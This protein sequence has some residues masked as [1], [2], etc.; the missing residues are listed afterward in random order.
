MAYG[1][2]YYA[3]GW[4]ITPTGHGTTFMYTATGRLTISVSGVSTF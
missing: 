2:V 1:T 3:M 4:I